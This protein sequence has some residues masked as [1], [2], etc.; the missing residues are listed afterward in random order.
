MNWSFA[1]VNG[2][3][4]EIFFE[5]RKKKGRRT[6]WAHCYVQKTEYR[7]KKEQEMIEADTKRVRLSYRNKQYKLVQS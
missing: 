4:A 7:T 1:I 3:L 5:E 2:R 6:I